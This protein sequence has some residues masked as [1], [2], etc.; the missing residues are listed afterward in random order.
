M[1]KIAFL[2]SLF[3]V[4]LFTSCDKRQSAIDDLESFS[5]ELKENASEYTNEDWEEAGN[6]YQMLV[7]QVDQYE[8]TDEEL[9]EIGKFKARCI[10]YMS[11]G[12]IKQLEEGI[13]NMT[14]QIEGAMEEFGL[15]DDGDY[16]EED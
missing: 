4:A 8:Y 15:D 1:K 9:K 10:K 3:A 5:E 14:K 6:Q 16:S 7:E 11:K 2:L 13:H 12:A